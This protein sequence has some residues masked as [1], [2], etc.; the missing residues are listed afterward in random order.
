MSYY[1]TNAPANRTKRTYT[2]KPMS[3]ISQKIRGNPNLRPYK[4]PRVKLMQY[5]ILSWNFIKLEQSHR[6]KYLKSSRG[7][8]TFNI[9]QNVRQ[10][11]IIAIHVAD[12]GPMKLVSLHRASKHSCS[13]GMCGIAGLFSRSLPAGPDGSD[14]SDGTDG[15]P[16][17]L[18][19][20][21][22]LHGRVELGDHG[23]DVIILG[24]RLW[25]T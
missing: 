25:T 5:L 13:T 17:F 14:G 1:S 15:R 20:G 11:S 22:S 10:H 4:P 23:L 9:A 7:Q 2:S 3:N 19:G 16:F 12:R 24:A 8:D 21:R 18:S 6:L